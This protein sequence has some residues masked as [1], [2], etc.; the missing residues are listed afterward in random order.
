MTKIS[1]IVPVYNVEKYLISCLESLCAQTLYDIEI[2]CIDDASSDRSGQI[3]DEYKERDSRIKVIHAEKNVGTLH[4]RIL[5]IEKSVGEYIMFIDG[6]DSLE[7][8]A[9]YELLELHK[10][11]DVDVLHFGTNIHANE[12]VSDDLKQWVI[13]FLTPYKGMIESDNLVASCFVKEQFDFNITN[14]LWK[15]SIC[16]QAFSMVEK[17]RLVA[18]EDRYIFF[19]LMYYAK[20]YYGTTKKYYH[21]NIGIGIT[22]GNLLT[23][24]QFE[25]R[26]SGAQA[27]EL[28]KSFLKK[29]GEE[30][31]KIEAKEFANKILWDCLDCWHNKL[32]DTDYKR[33][34]QILQKYF[35]PDELVSAVARVYFE[36]GE[37]IYN[38]VQK[39]GRKMA[40]YYRYLG[41]DKMNEHVLECIF[42]LKQRGHEV[43][44]YTDADRRKFIH[45]TADYGVDVIYLPNSSEANWGDYER[46][47]SAFYSR[48]VKEEIDVL[49][50]ASPTSHIYLLDTLLAELSGVVVV[51]MK[52]EI[53]LD[54][55]QKEIQ[56]LN[57]ENDLLKK[58][59]DS[60]R[61]MLKAFFRSC[62]RKIINNI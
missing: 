33:G 18:S 53:Y 20:S 38:R 30:R 61:Q 58:Q 25:K 26:C 29:I 31:Y 62:K 27:T 54:D 42:R 5:G 1:I 45:D 17:V 22:G 23:L 36:Q 40:V 28:V 47:C 60:P 48:L 39:E 55:M 52:D 41:Y 51:D 2:V 57:Q 7:A 8:D 12:N 37:D 10:E 59:F 49:I 44:L 6:D 32:A 4:A 34:F 15:R 21:Y 16:E 46:R 9:C 19:I 35:M 24:E 13:R 56:R 50:Y 14:K 3:L 11:Y 43:V